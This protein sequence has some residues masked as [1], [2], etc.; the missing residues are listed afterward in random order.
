[1]DFSLF[2]TKLIWATV[3][4]IEPSSRHGAMYPDGIPVWLLKRGRV[5]LR[6]DDEVTQAK[7]G[8]W[9][10]PKRGK[11]WHDFTDDAVLLS[12]RFQLRWPSGEDMFE[13]VRT[14][15]VPDQANR[16][17][18]KAADAL[19]TFFP[20][21][22]PPMATALASPAEFFSRQSCFYLWLENYAKVMTAAGIRMRAI[23]DMDRRLLRARELLDNWALFKR[24]SRAEFAAQVGWSLAQLN[25]RF[26]AEYGTTP[27]GYFDRRRFTWIRSE[28]AHGE[29]TIKEIA[30]D[31]GYASLAQ[32]SNWFARHAGISPRNYRLR[33]GDMTSSF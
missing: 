7:A 21:Q 8:Q 2:E 27:R 14:L 24:I 25:R 33:A 31:A 15:V 11:S 12:M 26:A 32:F 19:A 9:I 16:Q 29:R 1:M 20:S 17:L 30:S 28:L 13:R 10:F 3:R 23:G 6:F 5:R 22:H 4:A 18:R